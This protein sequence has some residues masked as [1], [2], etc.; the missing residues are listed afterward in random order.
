M[1]YYTIR[2]AQLDSHLNQVTGEGT[3]WGWNASALYRYGAVSLGVAYHS[4]S[5]SE[6]R[7][8][9]IP[10]NPLSGTTRAVELD[11]D[12]HWHLQL[13][14]RYELTGALAIELDWTRTGWSKFNQI[15]LKSQA[16]G[17]T[18]STDTN[19]WKNSNAYRLGLTYDVLPKTQLRFGY[20]YDET[21][22]SRDY[23]NARVPDN[24][25]HLFSLGLGQDLGQGWG[26]EVSYMYV[27]FKDRNDRGSK[28]YTPGVDLG[29]E[30][31]GADAI[32]GDY[33]GN[34]HLFALEV[35]KA[36]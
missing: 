26:L 8:G 23:F 3:S 17:T 32:D 21:G 30:I 11:L 14:V 22:Q 1:D 9:L 15:E 18:M 6:L 13:G 16:T 10:R 27:R 2:S 33:K 4:A 35:S 20:A 29:K 5:I 36:F 31:N 34:A 25:R 28:S 12:L 24:D 7:G 19:E